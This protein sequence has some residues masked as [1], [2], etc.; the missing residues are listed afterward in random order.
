MNEKK[1]YLWDNL[2][3]ATKAAYGRPYLDK[4]YEN[5]ENQICWF[6][7]DLSPVVRAMRSGLLSMK[8]RQRYYVGRGAAT[9]ITM[10]PFLPVWLADKLMYSMGCAKRDMI[11]AGLVN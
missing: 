3:E 6:Q 10:F 8:P 1:E 2:A 5:F 9:I 11:P 4:I 7:S